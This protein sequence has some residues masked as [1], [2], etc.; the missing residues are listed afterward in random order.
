MQRKFLPL[1]INRNRSR[2]LAR[3]I[4]HQNRKTVY[5]FRLILC[6]KYSQFKL[7]RPST[8][9]TLRV[10]AECIAL[11]LR[12]CLTKQL[13]EER[14]WT[15]YRLAKEASASPSIFF[16]ASVICIMIT[17]IF[18][19]ESKTTV[20][21]NSAASATHPG[22]SRRIF[23]VPIPFNSLQIIDLFFSRNLFKI[24]VFIR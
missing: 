7:Q 8:A 21:T 10:Q 1:C 9:G 6:S 2:P 5:H 12:K 16:A 14:G 11:L 13:M 24:S 3:F 20:S 22:H 18:Y 17:S 4:I 19:L 23:P 15:D